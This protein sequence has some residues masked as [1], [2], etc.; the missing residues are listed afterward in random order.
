M[1]LLIANSWA[2]INVS[3][4][5]APTFMPAFFIYRQDLMIGN[6]SF[7]AN[8][9]AITSSCCFIKKK[10]PT[11]SKYGFRVAIFLADTTTSFF[12]LFDFFFCSIQD[13]SRMHRNDLINTGLIF[14]EIAAE[15]RRRIKLFL[16][17]F[18]LYSQYDN[19]YYI[20]I[21]E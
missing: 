17:S 13:D 20:L 9:M 11:L 12:S 6:S 21:F 7:K 2:G 15:C 4:M 3:R 8:G 10:S 5:M 16:I 1:I 19:V 18:I 14:T